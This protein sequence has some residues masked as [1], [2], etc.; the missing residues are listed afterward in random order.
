ML[1][2]NPDN[3]ARGNIMLRSGQLDFAGGLAFST[4]II[5]A[6]VVETA[7]SVSILSSL[8]VLIC[9]R[10]AIV[11]LLRKSKQKKGDQSRFIDRINRFILCLLKRSM[12]GTIRR[13][14]CIRRH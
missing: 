7:R 11:L 1:K 4:T 9:F 2:M 8:K 6:G 5:A 10:M 3:A 12:A 13:T 14:N